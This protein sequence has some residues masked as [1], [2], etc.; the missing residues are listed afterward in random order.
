MDSVLARNDL[1]LAES[2]VI[3]ERRS[4]MVTKAKVSETRYRG[5]ELPFEKLNEPGT[6]FCNWSGHLMRVPEDAYDRVARR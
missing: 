6:Y 1:Q 3:L 2:A 4:D 5:M